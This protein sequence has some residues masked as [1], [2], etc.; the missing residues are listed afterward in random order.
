MLF[1]TYKY[2]CLHVG[3]GN[4]QYNYFIGNEVIQSP[5]EERDLGVTIHQSLGCSSQCVK[6]AKVA[7]SKLVQ[8]RRSFTYNSKDVVK[9]IYKSSVRPHLEYCVQ[10]MAAKG[11]K[12][13]GSYTA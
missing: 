1:N 6:A 2:K 10:T 5:D 11:H 13:I 8:F 3:S 9:K 12:C 4:M 7:N